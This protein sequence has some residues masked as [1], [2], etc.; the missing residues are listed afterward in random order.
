MDEGDEVGSD[1][2]S[3]TSRHKRH[4]FRYAKYDGPPRRN[5]P[6]DALGDAS[7]HI[8]NVFSSWNNAYPHA[9]ELAEAFSLGR[10]MWMLLRQPDMEFDDVNH[11]NDLETDWASSDDVPES[12][13]GFVVSRFWEGEWKTLKE[14]SAPIEDIL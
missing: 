13:K 4:K 11:P 14:T 10:S 9:L 2:D 6:E 12:W 5:V 8:W 3:M 7:W 1:E